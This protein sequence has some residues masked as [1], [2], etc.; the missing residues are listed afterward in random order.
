[1]LG[2]IGGGITFGAF[3][4]GAILIVCGFWFLVSNFEIF[5]SDNTGKIMIWS[6]VFFFIFPVIILSLSAGKRHRARIKY[7]KFLAT[8]I[9]KSRQLRDFWQ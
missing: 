1:M 6:A 2:S 8:V 5:F 7:E 9:T 3:A 4:L